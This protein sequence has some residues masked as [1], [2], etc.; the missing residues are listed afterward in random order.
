MNGHQ[1]DI[2]HKCTEKPVALHFNSA[3]HSEK[4][5][6]VNVIER[7]HRN[8]AARLR[9][10]HN[11]VYQGPRLLAKR[12][13][14]SINEMCQVRATSNVTGNLNCRQDFYIEHHND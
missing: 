10:A 2:L 13:T 4:D 3:S 1:A 6:Q 9:Y 7:M 11:L 8:D 12:I 5:L 14:F